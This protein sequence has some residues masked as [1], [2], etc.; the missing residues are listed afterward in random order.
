MLFLGKIAVRGLSLE[1]QTV[2]QAC[3]FLVLRE[4]K[5]VE[6]ECRFEIRSRF[7]I[8][9]K[10]VWPSCLQGHAQQCLRHGL[11]KGSVLILTGTAQ[12][13]YFGFEKNHPK[14]EEFQRGL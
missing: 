9:T 6:F 2:F 11:Q 7:P 5:Y 1:D 10:L 4:I 8:Q 12:H 14:E 3:G 13:G